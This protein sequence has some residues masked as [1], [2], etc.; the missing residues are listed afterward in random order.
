MNIFKQALNKIKHQQQM[1]AILI[2]AFVAIMVWIAA[3]LFTSQQK[4][5]ISKD[6]LKMAQPLTPI[7]NQ[8]VVQRLRKKGVFPSNQLQK[9]PI[10]MI[11]KDK[12]QAEQ[13]VEIGTE[14]ENDQSASD[15]T[16]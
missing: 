14:P 9:F 13:I 1:L 5:S 15:S 12:G 7:I 8:E 3:T 6:L 4:T 10:Y 16:K 11:S 2:F